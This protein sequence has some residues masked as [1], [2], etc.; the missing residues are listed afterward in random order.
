MKKWPFWNSETVFPSAI[1]SWFSKISTRESPKKSWKKVENHEISCEKVEKMA[2]LAFFHFFAS[3]FLPDFFAKIAKKGQ[4]PLYRGTGVLTEKNA[5][6]TKKRLR[7]TSDFQK[8]PKMSKSDTFL[9]VSKIPFFDP[10]FWPNFQPRFAPNDFKSLKKMPYKIGV[11]IAKSDKNPIMIKISKTVTKSDSKKCQKVVIFGINAPKKS[12]F[13]Q[14]WFWGFTFFDPF[15]SKNEKN[16]KKWKNEISWP[17]LTR[18]F[19]EKKN[20]FFSKK[21]SKKTCFFS[22]FFDNFWPLFF[23]FLKN[24]HF[25]ISRP[26]FHRQFFQNFQT[27]KIQK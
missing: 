22:T 20:I 2:F 6:F 19:F 27:F 11:Q 14:F 4:Y 24:A 25:E 8:C 15:F 1:F 26:F 23:N 3:R 13:S 5:F 17:F 10:L 16:E 7:E 9:A 12:I 18:T 21:T